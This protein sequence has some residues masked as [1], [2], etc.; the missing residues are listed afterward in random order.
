MTWVGTGSSFGN[1]C[2]LKKQKN[3]TLEIAALDQSGDF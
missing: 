3:S 2:R 1:R